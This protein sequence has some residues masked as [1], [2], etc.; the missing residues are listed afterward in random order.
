MMKS[1]LL[2]FYLIAG[3]APVAAPITVA[4]E[5]SEIVVT[6]TRLREIERGLAECL[7][8]HCPPNEDID[9]TLALTEQLFVSGDYK[10]ARAITKASL[11]RNSRHASAFPVEVSDLQRANGRLAAHLGE[12]ADYQ[13][14]IWGVRRALKAG[15]PDDDP[16]L[17][18]ADLEIA[19]ML[20]A[21][22]YYAMAAKRYGAA[23]RDAVRIGR[24][25]LAAGARLRLA[26][27]DFLSSDPASGRRALQAL[28]LST[29]PQER[30]SRIGAMVILAQDDRKRGSPDRT[31]DLLSE[32]RK[33]GLA[34]PAL[35]FAPEVKVA[36]TSPR[37]GE[38]RSG[39]RSVGSDDYQ[40][41]WVDI[42]FWV[43]PDGRVDDA[44]LL[45]VSRDDGWA[46]PLLN[47]IRGRIYSPVA[48]NGSEGSYRVERYTLTSFWEAGTGT[49]LRQRSR[50]RIEYLDL[51]APQKE[52]A[53][54]AKPTS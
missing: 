10:A 14:S 4:P 37:D 15:L 52:S 45:R 21:T 2:V 32:L 39:I 7:A 19:H 48:G 29:K 35:L 24:R 53:P 49:R 36:G 44:Q 46:T 20:A 8:R 42:G 38:V 16:R 41:R 12:K 11:T 30:A 22:G 27:L 18:G 28:A 1:A 50:P 23:A 13:L 26:Y 34:Q 31:D 6:A 17:I 51:T 5:A 33:A 47:S 40:G 54:P 9:A 3:A 25:G 43:R